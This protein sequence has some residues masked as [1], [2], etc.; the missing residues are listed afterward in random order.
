MATSDIL[1]DSRL[2]ETKG[3]VMADW[4]L[5]DGRTVRLEAVPIYCAHC[6]IKYGFV[7]K[8]NQ[9]FDFWLC[10]KCFEKYGHVL[11]CY[12]QPDEEFCRDVEFEMMERFGRPL[13][14]IEIFAAAEQ[15]Q[16]GSAL[17]KLEK[18]SPYPVMRP[19]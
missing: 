1:P 12:V 19:A 7:P 18:D 4:P 6:G 8:E 3:S 5:P 10:R 16:L 11:G 2:K 13:T 14:D 9:I 17:E 15:G